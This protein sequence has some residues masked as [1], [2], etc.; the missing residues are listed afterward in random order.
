[1]NIIL[2]DFTFLHFIIKRK[3]HITIKVILNYYLIINLN[4]NI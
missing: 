3:G 2:Y 4:K 1:M